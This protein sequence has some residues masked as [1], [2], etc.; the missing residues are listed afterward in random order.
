MASRVNIVRVDML[1]NPAMFKDKFKLEIT[2]EVY[3]HLQHDLK[4]ELVYVGSGTSRDYDQ[5][6]DS[7]LVG[8]VPVGRHK[9]VFDAD[10][11]DISK[12][13]VD[14]IV[15]VSVLLLRCKYNEQEFINMGWFVANEYTDEE[16]KENPP[17]QPIVEKLSRNIQTDK[18]RVT[19]FP[20]RWADEDPIPE[21]PADNNHLHAE[22]P[23]ELNQ[24]VQEI[25]DPVEHQRN[26]GLGPQERQNFRDN[27]GGDRRVE[28][29]AALNPVDL[30]HLWQ[31]HDQG[32]QMTPPTSEED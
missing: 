3:E 12:I 13:P 32:Q 4:W 2:F 31:L 15:G 25:P 22:A 26:E 23:V 20:I 16:L 14:D 17:A 18:P 29:A 30:A 28:E 24:A 8:P 5:V 6:L 10:H 9:F 1:D 19:T 21:P 7:A 11:P 27:G